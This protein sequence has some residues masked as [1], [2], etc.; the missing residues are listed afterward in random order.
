VK[1]ACRD[2]P[3]RV[4][5]DILDFH[6]K[7]AHQLRVEAWRNMWRAIGAL[8]VRLKRRD[9]PRR[10]TP[11]ILDFHIKRAHQLRVEAWRNMWRAI[12]ALLVRLKRLVL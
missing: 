3:R 6:I 12:G 1:P 10:V 7:R 2:R 9:R 8:L 5:P 4:T 11:D